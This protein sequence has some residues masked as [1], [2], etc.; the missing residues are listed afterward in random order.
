MDSEQGEAK[1]KPAITVEWGEVFW[2]HFN[3][4]AHVDGRGNAFS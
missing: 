4:M 2:R 3:D 1:T